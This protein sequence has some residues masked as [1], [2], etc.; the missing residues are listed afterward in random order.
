MRTDDHI[1]YPWRNG[2]IYWLIA[3]VLFAFLASSHLKQLWGLE[4]LFEQPLM[5]RTMLIAVPLIL[6]LICFGYAH[7]GHRLG[8][9]RARWILTITLAPWLIAYIAWMLHFRTA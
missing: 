6:A 7:L 8:R 9:Q 1:E 5:N 3:L 2:L 4:V